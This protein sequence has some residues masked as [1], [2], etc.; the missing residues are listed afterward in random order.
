MIRK[1]QTIFP[2]IHDTA[3][4]ANDAN[5]VGAYRKPQWLWAIPAFI[6]LWASR[7]WLK[8]HRGRL[9][10]DPINFALRDPPSLLLAVLTTICF[11]MAVI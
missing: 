9:D 8:S 10:D 3:F 7:I 1:F 4:I 5:A 11:F 6:F 2:K